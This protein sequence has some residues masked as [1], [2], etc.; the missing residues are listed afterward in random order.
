MS[1]TTVNIGLSSI[2]DT[3]IGNRDGSTVQVPMNMVAAAVATEY[4]GP[5]Y[6]TRGE[7]YADLNWP[8]DTKGIVW[9]DETEANRGQYR[10]TGASGAGAWVR[11]AGL[12]QTALTSAQLNAKLDRASALVTDFNTIT[13]P[14]SYRGFDA[15]GTPFPG[16]QVILEHRVGT[17]N[18]M[19]QVAY[20]QLTGGGAP[21]KIAMR[22]IGVDGIPGAW[23]RLVLASEIGSA[24]LS[25]ASAFASAA[26]GQIA[27]RALRPAAGSPVYLFADGSGGAIYPA[28][29]KWR[30]V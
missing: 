25:A 30:V 15:A 23:D 20:S 5:Q 12:P 10:K 13:V 24:A 22:Y 18:R 11:F 29:P 4:P 27:E 17:G 26:Q 6:P 8:A 19:W 16:T 1:I 21:P 28:F 3:L 7:L 2:A 9:S 14:G